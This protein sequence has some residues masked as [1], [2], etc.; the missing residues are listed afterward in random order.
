MNKKKKQPSATYS[1]MRHAT[2]A[3]AK[4]EAAGEVAGTGADSE[5]E[6]ATATGTGTGNET[7]SESESES[8]T[9]QQTRGRCSDVICT[10]NNSNNNNKCGRGR[11]T[12]EKLTKS[13]NEQLNGKRLTVSGKRLTV[14][15]NNARQALR[16]VQSRILL[17]IIFV[18]FSFRLTALFRLLCARLSR[19]FMISFRRLADA[20]TQ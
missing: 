11:K 17:S 2:V 8:E 14:C 5:T 13:N 12:K 20:V 19:S 10:C 9:R 4:A 16:A 15:S 3:R 7:E 18:R 6:T 1:D